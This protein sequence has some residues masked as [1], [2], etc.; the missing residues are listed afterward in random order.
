MKR[1]LFPALA[2]MLATAAGA[3]ELKRAEYVDRLQ[4]CE[5]ILQGFTSNPSRGIPAAV[6]HKAKGIVIVNQVQVGLFFGVKDGWGGAMVKK[7]RRH[8][9]VPIFIK[10]GELSF[11]LQAGGKSVQT[12]YLLMD[13]T[14]PRLLFKSRFNFGID[15]KAVAGPRAA[16]TERDTGTF[17]AQVYV[18]SNVVGLYA[19]ATVK[20]GSLSP[21]ADATRQFYATDHGIPEILFSDWVAPQ[22]E[23]VPLMN[24][25][26]Q[27]SP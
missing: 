18:Y 4:T 3:A 13:D 10:A 26:Q 20:T 19:G 8:W 24:R 22:P 27:L 5:A 6:L 11:G 2:L 21:D 25:L 9:S 17:N 16:E 14:A 12:I 7:P 15:A 1:L 23:S